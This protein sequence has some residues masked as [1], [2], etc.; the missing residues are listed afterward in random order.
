MKSIE[1]EFNESNPA[2]IISFGKHYDKAKR[3]VYINRSGRLFGVTKKHDDFL[4][5]KASTS[6]NGRKLL[7]VK[8]VAKGVDGAVK[9]SAIS[10]GMPFINS[11][12]LCQFWFGDNQDNWKKDLK[13]LETVDGV[14]YYEVVEPKDEGE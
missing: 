2:N 8:A 9:S 10:T 14:D 5:I 11:Q 4:M 6:R 7:S 1:I 3:H 13:L 12:K